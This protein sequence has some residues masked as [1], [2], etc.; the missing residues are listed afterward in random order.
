LTDAV[1][2]SVEEQ[3]RTGIHTDFRGTPEESWTFTSFREIRGLLGWQAPSKKIRKE[4][5]SEEGRTRL[6]KEKGGYDLTI[7]EQVQRI[8]KQ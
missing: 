2:W 5:K 6:G 7:A 4:R 8:K 3:E 1:V